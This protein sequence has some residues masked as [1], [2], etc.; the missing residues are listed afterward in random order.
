MSKD[1]IVLIISRILFPSY[2]FDLY[3]KVVLDKED[4]NKIMDIVSKNG[5]IISTL[6][7]IFN[8]F[9]K[10]FSAA[11][12][13]ISSSIENFKNIITPFTNIVYGFS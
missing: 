13:A 1:S 3:E 10:F 12:F 6:K 8:R 2:F 9:S 4:E 7:Y 5:N 11:T